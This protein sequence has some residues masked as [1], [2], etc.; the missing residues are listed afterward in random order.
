[1]ADQMLK[2]AEVASLLRVS[3]NTAYKYAAEGK[4]P[5]VKTSTGLV[6]IRKSAVDAFLAD[7]PARQEVEATTTSEVE[8]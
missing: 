4:L 1:M 7:E 2:I 5:R 8:L 6:R 3:R